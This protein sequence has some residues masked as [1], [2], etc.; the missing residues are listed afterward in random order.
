MVEIHNK[1]LETD[2][3]KPLVVQYTSSRN[4]EGLRS[5]L[6]DLDNIRDWFN[7]K[8]NNMVQNQNYIAPDNRRVYNL[9]TQLLKEG[10]KEVDDTIN[11]IHLYFSNRPSTGGRKRK[12]RKS[13]KSRRNRRSRKH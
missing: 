2:R 10:L 6:V 9:D 13:R 1:T 5:L 4:D 11:S 3:I 12:S 8:I 7:D